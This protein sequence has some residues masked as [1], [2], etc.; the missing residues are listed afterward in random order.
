VAIT[1]PGS[2]PTPRAYA[3][4]RGS[5]ASNCKFVGY[6]KAN[7]AGAASFVDNGSISPGLSKG[8]MADL[9]PQVSEIIF[10]GNEMNQNNLAEIQL[11]KELICFS[12]LNLIVY[13]PA[14]MRVRDN[15]AK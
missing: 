8:L 14:K 11:S 6:I 3:V 2:G 1:A 10:L 4:Y 5:S 15:I 13:Q 7:M 12:F 9:D